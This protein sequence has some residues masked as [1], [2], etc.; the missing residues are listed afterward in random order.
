MSLYTPDA[1]RAPDADA[2][3]ALLAAYPFATLITGVAGGEPCL[4]HLPLLWEP[5]PPP[6]GTLI[7]HVAAANP[8]ARALTAGPSVAVFTGPHCYITPSW[9]LEPA[10]MV[11]TWNYAAVHAH[12]TL[13]VLDEA[14]KL[15]CIDRLT[16]RFESGRVPPWTRQL[17]GAAL[18]RMLKAI[19]AF[20]M[21][22]ARLDAKFK[23]SQNRAAVDQAGV[24][25]GLRAHGGHDEVA[26]AD[27]M[28][29][30]A[31]SR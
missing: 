23:M 17:E 24:I 13:E 11:P 22:I 30:H 4:S 7:G 8:H 6:H 25:D 10:K 26:V 3:S 2:V 18:E 15:D 27:W 1:F 9:Y 20:R 12:G 19:V 14:G 31:P 28:Q 5:S 29:A 16:A 21:P